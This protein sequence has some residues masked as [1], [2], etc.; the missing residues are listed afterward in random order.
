MSD[1]GRLMGSG[2]A[3]GRVL[4]FGDDTRSFLAVARGLGRIGVEV[5]AAPADFRAP[6]LRSRYVT[7]V[8]RLPLYAADG[9]EW[10]TALESLLREHRFDVVIPCNETAL[11][12][13]AAHRA[14]LAAYARLAI[15]DDASIAILF[16]KART[17]EL[18]QHCGVPVAP[19]R[20]ITPGDTGA[21]LLTEFGGG[22]V[23]KPSASYR[24]DALHRRGRVAV[25][26]DADSIDAV[27]RE[28]DR[29][30]AIV[31]A[32]VPGGGFGL[33]VLALDG[34]IGPAFQHARV[35]ETAGASFYRVSAPVDPTLRAWC[36][37]MLGSLRYS[38]L[39][40]FEFRGLPGGEPVL[41]EVNARPWGSMPLPLSLGV[42]FPAAW[43]R[44]IVSRTAQAEIAYPAPIY[45]RNLWPDVI[46][47]VGRAASGAGVRERVQAIGAAASALMRAVLG[48]DRQDV[49]VPDDR[50][51]AVAE[52]AALAREA[53]HR[54]AT[55]LPGATARRRDRELARLTALCR[56]DGPLVF[57]CL[58][59]ICRSPFA[60]GMLRQRF[61]E[62]DIRSAGTLPLPG[63]PSPP[64][65]IAE[66]A[67]H[68]VD[69]TTHRSMMLD[70]GLLSAAATLIVFDESTENAVLDRAPHA[71]DRLIRLDWLAAGGPITDP[72]AGDAL[73]FERCY[74]HI[75]V[76]IGKITAI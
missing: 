55:R 68:G 37:A 76:S 50:A 61:P 26:S 25:L 36:A 60:A 45:G 41:L 21:A 48:L 47:S 40:M 6:A 63:R 24:L 1:S 71:A 3:R 23:V 5:H 49:W 65:A 15:P 7:A 19:G 67:R 27:L 11:L 66:A 16:D 18:A 9:L 39:A 13:L 8:H 35:R 4:V 72:V 64:N 57:V 10:L 69:L 34:E 32:I 75:L 22:V 62:R 46:A 59:N 29:D 42:N 33:S 30:Q 51:P 20:R 58:G 31:E 70:D 17:R 44:Q 43:Y 54:L 14:R 38:G 28:L 52:T 2:T 73:V 74:A 53:L 12:P 56:R